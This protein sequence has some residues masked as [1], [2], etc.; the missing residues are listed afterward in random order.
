M[1]GNGWDMFGFGK[2]NLNLMFF[3]CTLQMKFIESF[4]HDGF[5]NRNQ[6]CLPKSRYKSKSINK[7][8]LNS[9]Y[10]IWTHEMQ[11]LIYT[12]SYHF[13][14]NIYIYIYIYIHILYK[15]K[16]INHSTLHIPPNL[17]SV[18]VISQRWQV[19]V[20]QGGGFSW[21]L[22]QAKLWNFWLVKE[23]CN[24]NLTPNILFKVI[25]L[26]RLRQF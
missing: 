11:V 12:V 4:L 2:W 7:I 13:T 26:V 20:L 16:F 18:H 25:F 3:F 21:A 6:C 19:V 8:I 5:W 15:K 1:V 23:L 9:K 14:C 17:R 24:A 10:L 22:C